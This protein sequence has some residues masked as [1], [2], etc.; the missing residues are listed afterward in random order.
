[1][2]STPAA[3]ALVFATA[4][5][6]SACGGD[7]HA[8]EL[9]VGDATLGGVAPAVIGATADVVMW[10]ASTGG[11][12]LVAGSSLASLPGTATQLATSTGPVAHDGEHVLFVADE[13]ISRAGIDGTVRRILNAVPDVLAAGGRPGSAFAWTSGPV[14]SW[15]IDD[16]Q[17]TATLTKIDRCDHARV[18]AQHVYVA[19]DGTSG[20]RLLR[21]DQRTGDVTPVTAS[22]TWAAMFPGGGRTGATYRGRIADA[23]DDGA[24]WLVEEIPSGRGIVVLEPVQ[25]EASVLLEHLSGATAFF[26]SAEALYWQEGDALLTAPRAGGPASIVASLPGPAGAFAD[27]Y[28]YFTHGAAIERLRVE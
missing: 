19:C 27:G 24:L 4:A 28:V 17:M 25:G 12:T 8:T 7:D 10:S 11:T 22:S 13:L 6:L 1:M 15:G 16:T 26:R 23:D 2:P 18:T 14:A 20:R 3:T 21:I 5:A 9:V